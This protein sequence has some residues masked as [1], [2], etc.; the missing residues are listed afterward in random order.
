M[1]YI[2]ARLIPI[3]IFFISAYKWG[4][5]KQYKK[6]YPTMLFFGMGDLI[7]IAIFHHKP[8][9]KFP[10]NFLIPPLDELLLIFSVFF[11]TALIFL[12][13][14]PKKLR[15]KVIYIVMWI[16]I[17]MLVETVDLMTGIIEYH[18]G[19]SY[20]WSLLHNTIQF[21]LIALHHRK[22]ILTWIIALIFLI[23]IM[24]IFKVP[25]TVKNLS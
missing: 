5:W 14:Y 17:Y 18:N 25:F 15:S 20:W 1:K 16:A 21:P 9:W 11:P 19:W 22:P 24:N 4:D 12:T 6:Y 2:L 8:L 13:N 7:Y 23:I 10:T 3:C